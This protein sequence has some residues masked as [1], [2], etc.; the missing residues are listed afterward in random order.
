MHEVLKLLDDKNFLDSLYRFAYK[1]ANNSYEAE[2]LCSDII[3]SVLSAAQK[4]S[5]INN[6]YAFVWTIARRVYADFSEKRRIFAN[7]RI[8]TEY[9]DDVINICADPIDE[10]VENENDKMQLRRI[11]RE[12]CFLSKIYR[13][14]CVMYYLDEMKI[15]DI[16]QRLEITENAVK[17]RLHSARE[18]IKKGAEKNGYKKFN[19]KTNRHSLYRHGQSRRKRPANC[20]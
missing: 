17:Q 15:S 5:D 1:R 11:M 2:D 12:I 6:P 10:Y 13:D 3:L 14:V 18:T 19:V 4:N 9:S 16:A 7:A 8:A 20:C